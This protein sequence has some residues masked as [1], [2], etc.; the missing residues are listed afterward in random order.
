MAGPIKSAEQ[1]LRIIGNNEVF[2]FT[3]KRQF[4]M[5]SPCSSCKNHTLVTAPG[6][7]L[8]TPCP[9]RVWINAQNDQTQ[10]SNDPANILVLPT[11]LYESGTSDPNILSNPVYST[12]NGSMFIWVALA[13]NN[14][15]L[16]DQ[17][18]NLIRNGIQSPAFNVDTDSEYLQCERLPYVPHDTQATIYGSGVLHEQDQLYVDNVQNRQLDPSG[19]VQCIS[20]SVQKVTHPF[21]FSLT[22]ALRDN[23]PAGA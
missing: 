12:D 13:E 5:V 14:G 2:G 23:C 3:P 11:Y 15:N 21:F 18:G 4:G 7:T 20:G 10:N 19:N 17:N 8:H 1:T 16:Y 6:D 9:R 22:T